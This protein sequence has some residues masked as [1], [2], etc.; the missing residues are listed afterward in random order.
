MLDPFSGRGSVPLQ[1]CLERRIGVG[2]DASPLAHLLTSAV[3]D[4]PS[5]RHALD[6]LTRLHIDWTLEADAWRVEAAA[7]ADGQA[8]AGAAALFHPETL[9]QLLFLRHRLDRR[10]QVDGF[11]LAA[12]AGILHGRRA[13]NLSEAMPNGFSL[14]PGY[15]SR[16]LAERGG[17]APLRPVFR[18]LE[19]R[20]RHLYPRGHPGDAR[21]RAARQTRA[22]RGRACCRCWRLAACPARCD[23]W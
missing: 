20:L 8:G 2:V 6:R 7:M 14:A 22:R 21:H 23:S 18:L 11:L 13:S 15:T 9:A 16:W 17:A 19:R 4:P 10:D 3:V 12:L 1:A 5:L